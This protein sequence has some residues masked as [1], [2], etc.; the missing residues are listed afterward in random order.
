[1]KKLLFAM[2]MITIF[3]A[4]GS[5]DGNESIAEAETGPTPTVDPALALQ[6]AIQATMAAEQGDRG[7]QIATWLAELETAES[8]WATN[9]LE[10]YELEIIYVNSNKSAIQIH[11]VVVEGGEVVSNDVRC[12]DQQ[13]NCVFIEVDEA[14]LTIPGL[15]GM[16]RNALVNDEVSDTS[17]G[18]QFHEAYGFPQFIGLQTPGGF[19]WY[20]QVQ[21]FSTE[22][23]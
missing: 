23:S 15:F 17:G 16:A 11:S 3:V 10:N 21:S 5:G 20:W 19:P 12:S 4:C 7:E 8:K 14:L 18:F 2:V 9:P 22:G 6:A 1:M 13:P